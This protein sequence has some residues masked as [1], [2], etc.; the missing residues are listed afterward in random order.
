MPSEGIP[1][2]FVA[3]PDLNPFE[4]ITPRKDL[5]EKNPPNTAAARM[6]EELDLSVPDRADDQ[7]Y[8][9]ILWL[10]LKGD[11]PQPAVHS[12]AP[13]HALEASR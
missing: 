11:A 4:A 2:W 3:A 5:N 8:N 10:M 12:W 9:R 6:S 7:L 1:R 13:L